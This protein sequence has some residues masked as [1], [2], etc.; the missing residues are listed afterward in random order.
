MTHYLLF[1]QNFINVLRVYFSIYTFVRRI[2]YCIK[3]KDFF[4][5]VFFNT[6]IPYIAIDLIRNPF[7]I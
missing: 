1:K 7:N 4:D 6:K 5:K 3:Y 2:K